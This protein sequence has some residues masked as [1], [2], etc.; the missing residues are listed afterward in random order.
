M[1]AVIARQMCRPTPIPMSTTQPL[2]QK[3]I[4]LWAVA[5][6]VTL[7]IASITLPALS[8]L[9]LS[10]GQWIVL[11]RYMSKAWQWLLAT[12]IGGYLAFAVLFFFAMLLG[13]YLDS[14]Y[15]VKNSWVDDVSV[16]SILLV[17]FL[18]AGAMRSSVQCLTLVRRTARY[19]QWIWAGAI[20][21]VVSL[22]TAVILAH[23]LLPLSLEFSGAV[24]WM[25]VWGLGGL[26][27]GWI[28]A[29]SLSRIFA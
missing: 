11:Q 16:L 21:T 3:F 10:V 23:T 9:W 25:S 12:V 29:R 6:A 26:L 7:A 18:V 27:G 24:G 5:T 13:A 8:P 22:T 14:S 4:I 1:L 17:A 15:M 19:R 20:A 2:D 28:E